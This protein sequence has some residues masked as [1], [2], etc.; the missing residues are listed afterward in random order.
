MRILYKEATRDTRVGSPVTL[1][2]FFPNVKRAW[3]LVAEK[4][5]YN[6][7]AL[8]FFVFPSMF[9]RRNDL[10]TNPRRRST[11]ALLND[12]EHSNESDAFYK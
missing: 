12:A 6:A 9:L 4:Q 5:I 11:S 8:I 7:S 1:L 3:S 10:Q 2:A